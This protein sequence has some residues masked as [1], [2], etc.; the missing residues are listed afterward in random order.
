MSLRRYM[1]GWGGISRKYSAGANATPAYE[2]RACKSVGSGDMSLA[3]CHPLSTLFDHFDQSQNRRGHTLQVSH[4]R[5]LGS[6]KRTRVSETRAH[7]AQHWVDQRMSRHVV[8][9]GVNRKRGFL[10]AALVGG[11]QLVNEGRGLEGPQKVNLCPTAQR[12]SPLALLNH[13]CNYMS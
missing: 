1:G 6:G 4:V 7:S 2:C 10:Y 13:S 5:V 8:L 12:S 3:P 9:A 11:S